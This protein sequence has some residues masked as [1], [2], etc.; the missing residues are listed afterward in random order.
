MKR[1]SIAF[2]VAVAAILLCFWVSRAPA[3]APHTG[4][5]SVFATVSCFAEPVR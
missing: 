2:R 4:D 5:S 3:K 1:V